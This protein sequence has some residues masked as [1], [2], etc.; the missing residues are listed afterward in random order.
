M[1]NKDYFDLNIHVY[2]LYNYLEIKRRKY[3]C[4]STT[5]EVSRL[6]SCKASH[7]KLAVYPQANVQPRL[8]EEE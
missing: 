5:E 2:I 4:Q 6:N 7:Q 3:N 1:L 8:R